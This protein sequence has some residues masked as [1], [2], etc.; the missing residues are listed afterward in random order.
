MPFTVPDRQGK[1]LQFEAKIYITMVNIYIQIVQ[2]HDRRVDG[3]AATLGLALR[4]DAA[5]DL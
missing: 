1:S 3:V 4:T 2:E 5:S